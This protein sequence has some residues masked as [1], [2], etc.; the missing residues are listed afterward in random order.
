MINHNADL[1]RVNSR[2][3][4]A[5]VLSCVSFAAFVALER[6]LPR[7][8]PHV[9]PQLTRSCRSVVALV[10]LERLFSCVV[11]HH[12]HF[13]LISCN[14]GKLASCASVRLFP[15]VGSFVILKIA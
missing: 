3:L 12:V 15:R 7:V 10:T 8:R 1:W 2:M 4:C 11:P 6:S 9:A 13:Q 5:Q 14:T